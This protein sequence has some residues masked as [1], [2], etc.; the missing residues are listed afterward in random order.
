MGKTTKIVYAVRKSTLGQSTTAQ[1]KY[2]AGK[3][4]KLYIGSAWKKGK[5]PV[6]K[7][8][9]KYF[10]SGESKLIYDLFSADRFSRNTFD[11][12]KLKEWLEKNKKE[13]IVIANRQRF[14]FVKDF[15]KFIEL[16][17][18]PEA[19]SRA[20]SEKS[21]KMWEEQKRNPQ[22]SNEIILTDVEKYFVRQI[23]FTT[24]DEGELINVN[25]LYEKLRSCGIAK[26]SKANIRKWRQ[27]LEPVHDEE[28]LHM[29]CEETNLCF[30]HP[31]GEHDIDNDPLL[32]KKY[33]RFIPHL[34]F[35]RNLAQN[36]P[37]LNGVWEPEKGL[38]NMQVMDQA[39]DDIIEDAVIINEEM[40]EEEMEEEMEDSAPAPDIL[41]KIKE[42]HDMLQAN[43][44]TNEEFIAIKSKFI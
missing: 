37:E 17:R 22:Y 43:I 3:R 36:Y 28:L 12:Y 13:L 4:T 25:E 2:H 8:I 5:N 14:N 15:D 20:I 33:Q 24:Y 27:E 31:K 40:E 30:A 44:I 35:A 19:Q 6:I 39:L 1:R 7:D 41:Q 9:Y 26:F 21:K 10:K 42:A 16:I 23:I 11:C 32:W 18:D 38:G 34:E 29:K